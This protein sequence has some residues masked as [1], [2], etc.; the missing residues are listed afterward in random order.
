MEKYESSRRKT[1][2]RP[3][4]KQEVVKDVAS[5]TIRKK[6]ESFL[7]LFKGHKEKRQR[8]FVKS[9]VLITTHIY[10]IYI[11][12]L[13]FSLYF[14]LSLLSFFLSQYIT[15]EWLWLQITENQNQAQTLTFHKKTSKDCP[16]LLQHSAVS[17]RTTFCFNILSRWPQTHE[18]KMFCF[19][20]SY[21]QK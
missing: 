14:F 18:D 11:R 12:A 5:E 9:K 3:N 8:R 10:T 19:V 21:H 6:T 15:L 7:M 4:G 2:D 1:L 16:G 20:F 13:S 17:P